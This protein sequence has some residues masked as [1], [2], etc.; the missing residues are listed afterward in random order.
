MKIGIFSG[1]GAAVP[2]GIHFLEYGHKVK[3]YIDDKD[4]SD[5][6]NGFVDKVEDWK[7]LLG[8]C[9]LLVCDDTHIAKF[10]D[11]FRDQGIPVIGG[12]VLTDALE[13]DRGMGQKLFKSVGLDVL[14]SREF[15]TIEEAISYVQE[16]PKPYVVK[17]SGVA[18]NDKTSTYV[19]QMDDGSDIVPVLE[20]MAEKLEKGVKGV[21]IQ[22]KVEG[23]EVGISGFFNGEKFIGP[24]QVNFEHK[25]LM[26]WSTQKG[27]GPLTGEMGTSAYWMDQTVPLF[28]KVLAPMVK[29]LK[30]LGYHGDFD[31]NCIVSEGKI[32]PLE[33]TNRF[34]WPSLLM[35]LE[36]LKDNDLAE[37]FMALATGKDFDLSVSDLVSL[38]VVIG[39]PPLPYFSDEIFDK[40]SK[41]MPVLFL[42]GQV[43]EGLYPGEAKK[44]GDQWKVAGT[45]GCLA[46]AAAGGHSIEECADQAY[47]IADQVIVPNKMVRN[48]IGSTTEE[49]YEELQELGLLGA[50]EEVEI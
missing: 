16:N 34:G 47:Q 40:Y 41:D 25:A 29:P 33:M 24:C 5:V 38:C 43:P 27:I 9:D 45:S 14:E 32:Y 30:G 49:A 20:H 7:E 35:Q 12:T 11:K 15:K 48:D 50:R 13:E 17:V 23:I 1:W 18:Q 44:E 4:S 42:D 8:G 26:P 46:V 36:T 19:G 10:T 21:E 3:M 22:E 28:Q 37:F 2:L 39:V 6:G 31:I